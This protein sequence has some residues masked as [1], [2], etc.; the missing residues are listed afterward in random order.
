MEA[1]RLNEAGAGCLG[2]DESM[3]TRIFATRSPFEI[4]IIAQI[5]RQIAGV[6]LYTSLQKE[7]SGNV[8]DL[9]KAIFYASINTP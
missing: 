2:T 3:F 6:D 4:A 9:L 8:E 5:Y 7:F 1:Q